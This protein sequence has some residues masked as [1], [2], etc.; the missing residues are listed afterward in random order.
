MDISVPKQ[1]SVVGYGDYSFSLFSAPPLTTVTQPFR[2]LG[3]LAA[4]RL[5]DRI[6]NSSHDW[7]ELERATLPSALTMRA[8]TA[9]APL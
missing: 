7:D 5:L 6:A 3:K 8:S 1:L 4:N 2:E 9:S